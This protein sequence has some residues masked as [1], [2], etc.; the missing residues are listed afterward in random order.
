MHGG[1]EG[2]GRWDGGVGGGEV[3]G[4]DCGVLEDEAGLGGAE[5]DPYE[6][7]DEEY[8]DD[9]A[10]DAGGHAAVELLGLVVVVAAVLGHGCVVF[11]CCVLCVYAEGLRQ[12][13][14]RVLLCL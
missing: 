2:V 3:E 8:E 12:V 6:E 4:V 5:D 7:D 11:V 10:E 9:E 14:K 1:G 13:Q